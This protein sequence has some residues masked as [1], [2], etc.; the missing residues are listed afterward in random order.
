MPEGKKGNL[1][2]VQVHLCLSNGQAQAGTVRGRWEL[3][4]GPWLSPTR[5][6]VRSEPRALHPLSNVVNVISVLQMRSL[7]QRG[8]VEELERKTEHRKGSSSV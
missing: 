8:C 2:L 7:K 5:R 1:K 3:W 4:Q 6:P